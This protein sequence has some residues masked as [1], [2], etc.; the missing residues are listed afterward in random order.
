MV[1]ENKRVCKR[2]FRTSRGV[3][4][5]V[6]YGTGPVLKRTAPAPAQRQAPRVGLGVTN[7]LRALMT[8]GRR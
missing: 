4:V 8:I 5:C 3:L 2:W 6:S 7:F 1:W